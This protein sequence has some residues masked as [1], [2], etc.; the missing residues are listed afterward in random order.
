M[1]KKPRSARPAKGERKKAK[2]WYRKYTGEC[3][4]CGRDLGYKVREYGDPPSD[5]RNKVTPLS[6][7]GAECGCFY[8]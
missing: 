2:F 5:P 4:L 6:N 3:P 8:K 1:V 7:P